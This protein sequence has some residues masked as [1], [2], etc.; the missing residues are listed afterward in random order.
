MEMAYLSLLRLVLMPD[1]DVIHLQ[2][3]LLTFSPDAKNLLSQTQLFLL[4]VPKA[5]LK[6][7]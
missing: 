4:F 5:S 1:T 6:R 2:G 7:I 3:H